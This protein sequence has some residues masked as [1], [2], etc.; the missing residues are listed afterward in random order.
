MTPLDIE[1]ELDRLAYDG[2]WAGMM[3]ISEARLGFP[4]LTLV[5]AGHET[6]MC[7]RESNILVNRVEID[8]TTEFTK[9]WCFMEIDMK[10]TRVYSDP[11]M[12][13]VADRYEVGFGEQPR[14]GW[15]ADLERAG[16]DRS[17]I[18]KV[19]EHLEAHPPISFY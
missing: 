16:L 15:K 18:I 19:K 5:K 1:V 17:V 7:S 4:D 10:G 11:P 8:N 14:E 6:R 2:D 9:V 3:R 12:Y 13:V